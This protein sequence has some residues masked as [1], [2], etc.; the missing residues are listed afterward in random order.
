MQ[1][2]ADDDAADVGRESAPGLDVVVREVVGGVRWEEPKVE[3]KAFMAQLSLK[4]T[5]HEGK[6]SSLLGKLYRLWSNHTKK[7]V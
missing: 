3:W 7:F 5:C 6:S 4:N 1:S 2:V